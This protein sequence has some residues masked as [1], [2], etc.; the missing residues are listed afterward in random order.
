MSSLVERTKNAWNAFLGR[1][2][3]IYSGGYSYRPDRMRF[4]I[5]NA[6]SIVAS[7]YN[8]IAIDVSTS[9]IVH[10]RVN[11][12][13]KYE[14][15]I[16]SDL[17]NC[18]TRSAN[19]DQ[20]ARAFLRDVV[21]SMFDEGCVAI[22]PTLTDVNPAYTDSYKI[23]KMRTARVVE[24]YPENVR[25][26]LYREEV[27]RKEEITLSKKFVAIIENP[28]YSIMNEPNS[29]LQRLTRVLNQIDR[30]N[31]DN[32][33][34]KLDL[35]V[36]LPYSLKSELQQRRA[37]QR[38]KDLEE[39]LTGGSQYGIGYIDG[40]E[41]VIQLN[42]AVENNLWDQ[43]TDL[44]HQLYN[45][46]GLTQSIFDGTADEKTILN[47]YDRTVDP[48]LSAI[49]EEMERKWLSKTAISQK[50]A[51]VYFRDP[52]RLVPVSQLAE[53]SDKLTRNEILSSNEIRS[54][55]GYKPS[56]DPHADEL[57]NSNLNHPE[58]ENEK[59]QDW[60]EEDDERTDV[61][62]AIKQILNKS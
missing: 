16:D 45:Q 21:M 53:I 55:I 35:I 6:R 9:D 23:F 54:I 17:N 31:E 27:G 5:T 3:T 40:T 42:R 8:R 38:R 46:L 22:V 41:H 12:D 10:A 13:G 28:F 37:K 48:I 24:W 57:R 49:V 44:T 51:I 56:K 14:E 26:S 33:A 50:Q 47:Y 58:E 1:D 34:G 2:P 4:S 29:I 36:Q 30:T 7:I 32:S 43:A 20:P 39:Q 25:V 60:V 61:N 62:R 52:F 18:L 19:L 11:E 59:K 15:T